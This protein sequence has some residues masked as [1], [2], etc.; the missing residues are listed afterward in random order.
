[1]K[2]G[3]LNFLEPSGLPRACTGLIYL[4][5]ICLYA[6]LLYPMSSAC[7]ARLSLDLQAKY[8]T[9]VANSVGKISCSAA[10][11]RTLPDDLLSRPFSNTS[12]NFPQRPLPCPALPSSLFSNTSKCL[13]QQPVVEHFE[14][15]S[16]AGRFQIAPNIFPSS[17]FSKISKC[18]GQQPVLEHFE[19]Y[20]SAFPSRTPAFSLC[21]SLR[22]R[23]Y[24]Y[25]HVRKSCV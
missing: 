12:D 20:S 25:R 5:T 17:L 9:K 13:G 3:N 15:F 24:G 10:C 8:C 2:S 14:M 22:L 7:P 11:S 23:D 4:L 16:S 6:F 19:M 21:F 18:P 1:M